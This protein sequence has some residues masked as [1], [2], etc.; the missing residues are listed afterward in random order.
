MLVQHFYVAA[1]SYNLFIFITTDQ[2]FFNTQRVSESYTVLMKTT[3]SGVPVVAQQKRIRLGTM[4]LQ[5]R[6]LASLSE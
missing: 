6:S 1:Q 4:M 2:C 3:L 5:V